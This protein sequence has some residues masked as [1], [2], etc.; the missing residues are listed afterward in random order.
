[1]FSVET[2]RLV[3]SKSAVNRRLRATMAFKQARFWTNV[4]YPFEPFLF[5]GF[6]HRHG[7]SRRAHLGIIAPA[8]AIPHKYLIS[9]IK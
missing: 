7:V 8:A 9:P 4:S 5:T 2:K 3:L 6:I 1:L